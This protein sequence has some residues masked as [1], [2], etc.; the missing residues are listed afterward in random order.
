M[1]ERQ[2]GL[3]DADFSVGRSRLSRLGIIESHVT[4]IR[5][6]IVSNGSHFE[7]LGHDELDVEQTCTVN[8][9]P[10]KDEGAVVKLREFFHQFIAHFDHRLGVVGPATGVLHRRSGIFDFG[11]KGLGFERFF[12]EKL[13]QSH[14][15]SQDSGDC[16]LY[17]SPSPRDRQKSRMPSSA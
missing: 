14:A 1:S 6:L 10:A 7:G 12:K 15:V 5:I 17:T 4:P 2:D 3:T 8:A 9:L 11:V 16:L 13:R